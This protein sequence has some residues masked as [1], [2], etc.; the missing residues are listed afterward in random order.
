[1]KSLQEQL[2][3][4]TAAYAVSGYEWELG[5][6][7]TIQTIAGEKGVRIGDNLLYTLGS[8][9]KKVFVSAHMD[10]VGFFISQVEASGIRIMPIGDV[11]IDDV[12]G[13]KLR[14]F[15]DGQSYLSKPVVKAKDFSSLLIQGIPNPKIGLVGSFE[16]SFSADQTYVS[17]PSL[18][19]KV[20]CLALLTLMRTLSVDLTDKT[21][22]FCFASREE[23]NKNGIMS[24]VRKLSPDICIDVDSA[25]AQPLSD[26]KTKRNWQVPMLGKGPAIQL[27]GNGFIVR[28]SDRRL[29]EATCEENGIAYQYE[30]PDGYN[31]GTNASTLISS[32]Y[33]TM[34][35][36]IPV[37][38]QHAAASKVALKDIALTA[39][40]LEKLILRI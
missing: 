3:A 13:T 11:V 37:F 27:Q 7:D 31:G 36:N 1:M 5:I 25:Y 40:L 21:V 9:E 16:K 8:G 34:Q 6:V 24:A 32:G 17:G 33:E 38:N 23:I 28:S 14:F 35:I 20:G 26:N 39:Q 19:N 10:E 15:I 18:D 4:L 30:I 22:F 2:L 12:I 29:V